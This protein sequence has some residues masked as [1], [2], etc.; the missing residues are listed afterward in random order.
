MSAVLAEG[1]N[2]GLSKMAASS[3]THSFTQLARLSNWHV[4]SEAINRAL[5]TVLEAQAL[6]P[7]AKY[8]GAGETASSDGQFFPTTRQGEAM[9]LI[10]AKYGNEPGLK[11]YT[12]VSAL[13]N[14]GHSRHGE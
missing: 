12:H 9:N 14:P 8:W 10:N 1:L 3:S 2:L 11:A 13:R 7:M 4:E 6:L 5:A